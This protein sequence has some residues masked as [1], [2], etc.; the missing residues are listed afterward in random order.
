MYII[1]S[2]SKSELIDKLNSAIKMGFELHGGC[3]MVS[4]AF[5]QAVILYEKPVKSETPTPTFA[6]DV[7]DYLNKKTARSFR[8]SSKTRALISARTNEGYTK[9]DFTRVID[10]RCEKWL[11]DPKMSEYLR[12]ETLFSNKFES[13]LNSAPQNRR[14]FGV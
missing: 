4:G 5:T 7:I 11:S 1:H 14:V 12:P 10:N 13:Y 9:D 8:L 3:S 2:S 6:Q